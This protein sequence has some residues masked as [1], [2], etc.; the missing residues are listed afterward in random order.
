M[1]NLRSTLRSIKWILIKCAVGAGVFFVK[2]WPLFFRARILQ[3]ISSVGILDFRERR[4]QL[5]VA[6]VFELSRLNSCRKEPETVEFFT[7]SVE[8]G[9]VVFDVGANV[10]AYSLIAASDMKKAVTVY[11]FEPSPV[12][13]AVLVENIRLNKLGESIFAIPLAVSDVNGIMRFNHS[14]ITPGAAEHALGEAV[15]YKGEEFEPAFSHAVVSASLDYFV[16]KYSAPV[17]THLKIDVD[18]VELDILK[19]AVLCLENERLRRILVEVREGDEKE[20]RIIE[21]LRSYGFTAKRG[22]TLESSGCVN[23]IFYR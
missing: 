21:L 22:D 23:Y 15:D 11:A 1:M 18:G 7:D 9:D 4:I 8:E 14:D 2:L 3:D 12:N 6:S 20:K 5:R 19:G 10:G 16:S 13:Y 17:P